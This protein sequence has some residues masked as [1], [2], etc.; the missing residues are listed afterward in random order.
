MKENKINTL[1]VNLFGGPGAGKSTMAHLITG[2]L[3][4]LG[5]ECEYA[6]EWAKDMVFE[7]RTSVFR[8]QLY[9][10]A[11]QDYKIDR[12]VGH[13]KVIVTD[14]PILIG[15]VFENDPKFTELMVKRFKKYNN[16]NILV[17][18]TGVPF[19]GVG[20]NEKSVEEAVPFDI[21]QEQLLLNNN[22]PYV[23]ERGG[24]SNCQKVV[25][26]I[27]GRLVAGQLID[28]KVN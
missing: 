25:M 19:S 7:G 8:N 22:L 3:K 23:V 24:L 18:R 20:R 14:S 13:T 21:A 28:T 15:A 5:V 2:L 12:I 16:Y 11:K 27:M 6:G 17:D 9:I 4:S 10:S 1:V 26:D